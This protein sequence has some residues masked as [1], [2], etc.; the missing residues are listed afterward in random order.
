MRRLGKVGKLQVGMPLKRDPG[1]RVP[2]PQQKDSAGGSELPAG[3]AA[4]RLFVSPGGGK[5]S[6]LQN[7][8]A[9]RGDVR[10]RLSTVDRVSLL[11]GGGLTKQVGNG[12]EDEVLEA[13]R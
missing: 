7:L 2:P 6:Q 3:C 12:G 8:T 10:F 9:A 5:T 11:L 4:S 1:L 13:L